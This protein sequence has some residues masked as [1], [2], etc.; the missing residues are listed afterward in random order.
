MNVNSGAAMAWATARRQQVRKRETSANARI[1]P[2]RYSVVPDW[3]SRNGPSLRKY[4]PGVMVDAGIQHESREIIQPLAP[5]FSSGTTRV[6]G[7]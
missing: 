5:D 4:T 7:Y 2:C 1:T 3:H 6:D